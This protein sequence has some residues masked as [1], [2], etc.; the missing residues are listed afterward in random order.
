[1]R[2]LFPKII[3]VLSVVALISIAL[4]G[5]AL[6]FKEKPETG[7]INS[8]ASWRY[9][10]TVTVDTPEGEKADRPCGKLLCALSEKGFIRKRHALK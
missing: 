4:W 1:V 6:A 8:D 3:I 9:K 7:P 5:A 2:N 10:M